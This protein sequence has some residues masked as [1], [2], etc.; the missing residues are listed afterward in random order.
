MLEA[1]VRQKY[2]ARLDV[3]RWWRRMGRSGVCDE[4]EGSCSEGSSAALAGVV[5]EEEGVRPRL[6]EVFRVEGWMGGGAESESEESV[7]EVVE[8]LFLRS[9]WLRVEGVGEGGVKRNKG[10]LPRGVS[11]RISPRATTLR[12]REPTSRKVRSRVGKV[13]RARAREIWEV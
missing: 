11:D 5:E 9:G 13:A 12:H 2:D 6:R 7:S 4:E 8:V 1:S 10:C 3:S